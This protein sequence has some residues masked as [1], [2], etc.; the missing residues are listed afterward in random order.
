ME[1]KVVTI[2]ECSCTVCSTDH[3]QVIVI[4][5]VDE[6]DLALIDGEAEYLLQSACRPFQ[7]IAFKVHDWWHDLTPWEAPPVF[8]RQSF[9]DGAAQTLQF[10]ERQLL[11][12]FSASLPLYMA[13][14]SL[15][16]FF[17]LWCSYHSSRF[18]GVAA[19][20]PSVWYPDWMEYAEKHP[21]LASDVYLSLGKTEEHAKNPLMS[22][23]GCCIR[24]Q[25][26]LLQ[27]QQLSRLALEWNEGN[28]FREPGIRT[29]KGLAW[30]LGAGK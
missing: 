27:A 17:A 2:A 6:H 18:Q 16:G 21:C 19:V 28:H 12:H 26:A 29:A 20:S 9:G 1:K 24:R 7:L 10:V 25:Y 5:P 15:A 30:L 8:G 14:Y 4:Q 22:R 3:P 11:P 13:G 23:V